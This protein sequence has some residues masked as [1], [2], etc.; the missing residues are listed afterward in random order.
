MAA[1]VNTNFAKNLNE[2]KMVHPIYTK[3]GMKIYLAITTHS[4][5]AQKCEFDEN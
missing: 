1:D 2:F 5:D 4:G 3:L